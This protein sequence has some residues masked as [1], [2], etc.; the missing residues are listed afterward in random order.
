M[1]RLLA[2]GLTP[3]PTVNARKLW[4]A[5]RLGRP[6]NDGRE[7]VTV[8]WPSSFEADGHVGV[9]P[10]DGRK[11]NRDVADDAG[12]SCDVD[13]PGAGCRFADT[14]PPHMALRAALQSAMMPNRSRR[15]AIAYRDRLGRG[16][17]RRRRFRASRACAP[18]RRDPGL[19]LA[20]ALRK[21]V[22]SRPR[23]FHPKTIL[24]SEH[25][26]VS[27]PELKTNTAP[28]AVNFDMLLAALPT[29]AY[30]CSPD[31]RLIQYNEHAVQL[32]GRR[33]ALSD[34]AERFCG[35]HA[36]F[37]PDGTPLPRESGW[38]A[39]ALRDD[40]P[41]GENEVV[42]A[43]PDGSRRTVLSYVTPV[44]D[45]DGVLI[46]ATAVLVDVT[47]HVEGR[48]ATE[49]ALRA[50]E[51]NFRAFFESKAIGAVQVNPE[52]FFVGVNDRYCELTGRSEEH[53]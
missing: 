39:R 23:R 1:Q 19:S 21:G 42:I 31:G 14:R 37:S 24:R 17:G 16:R 6:R 51:A 48:N 38:M 11:Q 7:S 25:T 9:A 40:A 53:T 52:G 26:G 46:A 35:S 3:S 18:R 22:S 20:S 32:W 36:M 2:P 45:A 41:Y 30:A 13:M 27:L 34:P 44:H 29:P 12:L 28:D 43:R 49:A 10:G 50:S 15:R 33:P 47:R 5:R 8:S 4:T